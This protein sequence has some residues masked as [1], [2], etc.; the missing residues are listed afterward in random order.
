VESQKRL[1]S[2]MHEVVRLLETPETK[3]EKRLGNIVANVTLTA[4]H[5]SVD[6][7]SST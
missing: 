1:S 4:E 2:E 5:D 3:V 6:S 7:Q